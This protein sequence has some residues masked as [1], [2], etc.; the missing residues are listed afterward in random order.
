MDSKTKLDK[1]RVYCL[2]GDCIGLHKVQ[3]KNLRAMLSDSPESH[4]VEMIDTFYEQIRLEGGI[5]DD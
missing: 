2:S 5:L 1:V 4:V 3:Y